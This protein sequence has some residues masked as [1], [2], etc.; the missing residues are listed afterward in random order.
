MQACKA[1]DTVVTDNSRKPN[2]ETVT[3]SP[4]E[5]T[6]SDAG[7]ISTKQESQPVEGG[8]AGGSGGG[9]ERGY[10][11]GRE[12]EESVFS[13]SSENVDEHRLLSV[14]CGSNTSAHH[15]LEQATRMN[16]TQEPLCDEE[17]DPFSFYPPLTKWDYLKVSTVQSCALLHERHGCN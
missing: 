14:N 11:T 12:E 2:G 17:I 10:E 9:E 1:G 13:D 5:A 15:S 4:R 8:V 3:I 16:L 6:I 7:V